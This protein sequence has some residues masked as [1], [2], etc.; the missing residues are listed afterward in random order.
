MTRK[1]TIRKAIENFGNLLASV[2]LYQQPKW[3]IK[4]VECPNDSLKI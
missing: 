1:K 4:I 3:K 2:L